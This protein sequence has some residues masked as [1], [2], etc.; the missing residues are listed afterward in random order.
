MPTVESLRAG[1]RFLLRLPVLV[2]LVLVAAWA[3]LIWTL[4]ARHVPLPSEGSAFWELVS[5][6]AHAP[7]FGL[8]GLFLS[9]LVLRGHGGEW[10]RFHPRS[11]ALVLALVVAYGAIDEWHQ[12]H[13]PGRDASPL[14]IV[15][16]LTGAALV[17]WIAAYVGRHGASE[18]GLWVRLLAGVV[19]CVGA[20]GLA[21]AM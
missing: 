16:D 11:V 12:S 2:A 14:D 9:A 10:P 3:S 15:T 21:L 7:L 6:M 18:R 5:N 1:G 8:L 17:L 19:L 13:V 4:S 20:A